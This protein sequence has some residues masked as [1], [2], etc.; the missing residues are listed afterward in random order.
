LC[1]RILVLNG[2]KVAGIAQARE[3]T[4]EELGL[5]MTGTGKGLHAHE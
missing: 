3:T 2:G 1:D 4:K 5:M